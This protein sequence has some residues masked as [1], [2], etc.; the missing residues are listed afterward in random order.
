MRISGEDLKIALMALSIG[1]EPVVFAIVGW[2]AGP[3]LNLTN[4]AGALIGVVVGLGIMFWRIW[5]LSSMLGLGMARDPERE[6]LRPLASFIEAKRHKI[7]GRSGLLDV[8]RARSPQHLLTTLKDLSLVSY[9]FY[10]LKK[11][12]EVLNEVIDFSK[13]LSEVRAQSSIN[14]LK[15][16]KAFNDFLTILCVNFAFRHEVGGDELAEGYVVPPFKFEGGVQGL[17]RGDLMDQLADEEVRGLYPEALDEG[18]AINSRAPMLALAAYSLMKMGRALEANGYARAYSKEVKGLALELFSIA[19]DDL[20]AKGRESKVVKV[21]EL[22]AD[23][24]KARDKKPKKEVLKKKEED[25]LKSFISEAYK[26]LVSS[27]RVPPTARAVLSYLFVKWSEKVSFK[28]ALMAANNK[29][30]P[31]RAFASLLVPC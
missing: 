19:V 1:L 21:I 9:D 25:V 15:V 6:D 18:L 28:L 20:R 30:S 11:L 3:Y 7:I 8:M 16:L 12:D 26:T 24:A 22:R 13:T 17:L 5:K 2:Y 27:T 31:H 10:D 14:F 29:V 23:L 4:T